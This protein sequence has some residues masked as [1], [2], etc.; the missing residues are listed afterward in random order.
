MRAGFRARAP[1]SR[2]I[3]P[4][5]P[6]PPRAPLAASPSPPFCPCPLQLYDIKTVKI[7]TL[8]RPDG[9]KKAYVKLTKD[10]DALD[11]ANRIGIL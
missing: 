4:N 2:D 3:S 5:A 9:M 1:P 8:I 10:Y 11:V 7:N 6:P